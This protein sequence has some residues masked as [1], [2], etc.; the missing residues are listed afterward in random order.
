M[1]FLPYGINTVVGLNLQQRQHMLQYLRDNLSRAQAQM[2]FFIELKRVLT[3]G[4][5]VYLKL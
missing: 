2:K 5:L 4:D 1:E 3:K